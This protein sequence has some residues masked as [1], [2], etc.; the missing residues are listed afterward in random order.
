MPSIDLEYLEPDDP[1]GGG[2]GVVETMI[3]PP[4]LSARETSL[5]PDFSANFTAVDPET[6]SLRSNRSEQSF[7][8]CSSEPQLNLVPRQVSDTYSAPNERGAHERK[9]SVRALKQQY[10]ASNGPIL[11][12]LQKQNRNV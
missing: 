1:T 9:A 8:T 5:P 11:A 10:S 12:H 3:L 6:A 2:S 4:P 7:Q